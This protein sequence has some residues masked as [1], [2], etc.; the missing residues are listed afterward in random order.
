[1]GLRT[2]QDVCDLL[3]STKQNTK[4]LSVLTPLAAI[5]TEKSSSTSWAC[6][7]RRRAKAGQYQW[8]P[9][10]KQRPSKIWPSITNHVG[11]SAKRGSR[12][13]GTAAGRRVARVGAG[14]GGWGGW[15][16]RAEREDQ[17]PRKT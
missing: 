8:P 12:I 5:L 2:K 10:V 6:S 7:L 16:P 11:A 3:Q 17:S 4:K 13:L 1:M 9:S 14:E 15:G